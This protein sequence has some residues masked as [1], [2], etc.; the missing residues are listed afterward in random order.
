MIYLWYILSTLAAW[1]VGLIVDTSIGRTP[2]GFSCLRVIF[3]V[4]VTGIWVLRTIRDGK[5]E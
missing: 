2:V 4:I 1:W 3:P 5:K